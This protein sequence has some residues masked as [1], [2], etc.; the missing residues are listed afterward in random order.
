MAYLAF[1]LPAQ[2]T[3][4][5]CQHLTGLVG[6]DIL[7]NLYFEL[8]ILRGQR[9]AASEKLGVSLPTLHR[10][11]TQLREEGLVEHIWGVGWMKYYEGE[12]GNQTH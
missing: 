11:L 5:F 7:D 12:N 2:V 9:R 4:P 3:D 10:Y 8:P 6:S 1:D